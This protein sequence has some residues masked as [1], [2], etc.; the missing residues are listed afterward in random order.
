[1]SATKVDILFSM[2]AVDEAFTDVLSLNE[3]PLWVESGQ[4]GTAV[5]DPKKTF[6]APEFAM[7]TGSANPIP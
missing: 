6:K 3:S 4:S 5:S 7:R 1:M 2:L